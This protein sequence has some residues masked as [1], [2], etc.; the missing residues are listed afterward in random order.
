MD[1]LF[2]EVPLAPHE[3]GELFFGHR[4]AVYQTA[5]TEVVPIEHIEVLVE[6]VGVIGGYES[7]LLSFFGVPVVYSVSKV[8]PD[9]II[10]AYAG[11]KVNTLFEIFS[12][13]FFGA[14]MYAF[15]YTN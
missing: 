5:I 15:A 7:Q 2:E 4:D 11:T 13:N 9:T 6:N 8:P 1:D 10:L 14:K 12:K 3:G